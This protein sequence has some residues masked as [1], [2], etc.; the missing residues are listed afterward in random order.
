MFQFKSRMVWIWEFSS[1]DPNW[2]L[3]Q[4]WYTEI[5]IVVDLIES[6]LI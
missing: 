3:V 4:R 2:R 6:V 5:W 1:T